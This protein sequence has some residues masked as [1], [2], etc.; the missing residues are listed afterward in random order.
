M[1]LP[2]LPR[3]WCIVSAYRQ[4]CP[5]VSNREE[6]RGEPLS[7]T[8]GSHIYILFL[9]AV[10]ILMFHWC[11][12]VSNLF[13]FLPLWACTPILLNLFIAHYFSLSLPLMSFYY[14]YLFTTFTT[15]C[16]SISAQLNASHL[17][18]LFWLGWCLSPL[19]PSILSHS[20]NLPN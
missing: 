16:H 14:P 19:P 4:L 2:K 18:S 7:S 10:S 12:P 11:S 1:K 6:S 3:V 8:R 13:L 17:A 20:S 5:V 9:P 15:V